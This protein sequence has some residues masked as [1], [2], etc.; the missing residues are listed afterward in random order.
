[1]TGGRVFQWV[2]A[3]LAG[4]VCL[5]AGGLTAMA[6]P[7]IAPLPTAGL[8][9][10][11]GDATGIL[12]ISEA[13]RVPRSHGPETMQIVPYPTPE[14]PGTIIISNADRTLHRVLGNGMAERYLISVGRE[15]FTWTGVT[16]VGRKVEWPDWR[17][18]SAMRARQPTLPDYV[19][20]GPF[21]PLGARALYLYQGGR[22]TL[23]RIHGT[24][25]A[26]SL[27]G[28]ETSGC[29]RLSNADVINLF[30]KVRTG[31]KVI[32]K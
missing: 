23:F 25:N 10:S 13:A 5:A 26:P 31:T 15:G 27:G 19:P 4:A 22:D 32:V 14:A 8:H 30:T 28:D 12:H 29:F 20:P 7:V 17:P 21:N 16:T 24:N 18:P 1:M 9:L 2:W 6:W 3:V 11:A